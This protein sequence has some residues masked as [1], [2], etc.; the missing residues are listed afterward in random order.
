M[1]P[2]EVKIGVILRGN[3]AKAMT[4]EAKKTL[5]PNAA[6][7]R[8]AIAEYLAKRGYDVSG[9]D[10]IAWGGSRPSKTENEPGQP[11]ALVVG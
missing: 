9:D 7:A 5:A 1:P 2:D 8:A 11:A 4:T 3:L 10:E 6:I